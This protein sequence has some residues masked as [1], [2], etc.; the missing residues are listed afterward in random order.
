MQN[1]IKR[2]LSQ[3]ENIECIRRVI[4]DNGGMHRTE[5][6]DGI[7]KRFGFRDPKGRPQRSGCRTTRRVAACGRPLPN[8][9]AVRPGDQH[10]ECTTGTPHSRS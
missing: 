10:R 7:C 5:L 4:A 6:A 3:P 8:A 1:L 2:T 9:D